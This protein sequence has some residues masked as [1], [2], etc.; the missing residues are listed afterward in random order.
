MSAI[1]RLLIAPTFSVK[2]LA[3]GRVV[4]RLGWPRV[5]E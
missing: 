2:G 4:L 1:W 3:S 5:A